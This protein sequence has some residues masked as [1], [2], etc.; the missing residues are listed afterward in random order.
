MSALSAT[1]QELQ[2]HFNAF[3][4]ARA[5]SDLV[6]RLYAEAMGDAY[7]VE[8]AASSSC[9]FTLLGTMVTRLCLRPGQ[10]LADIGCGTGGVGLW[11][12][13]ALALRLTGVDISPTAIELAAARRPAFLPQGR[14]Q[15]R[16]G[17]LE[18]TGLPGGHA[19][20]VVCVDAM[21]NATDRTAAL[22]EIHRIL[23]PGR[24]MIT[25]AVRKDSGTAYGEQAKNAESTSTNGPANPPCGGA[26]TGC[27]SPTRPPFDATSVTSSRRTCCARRTG[28]CP[29]STGAVRA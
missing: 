11:L 6:T 4:A 13:R 16:V 12:A 22:R 15:F 2:K 29:V 3:H 19:H 1:E 25:R 9:D 8:V 10:V 28:C 23:H 14:A 26:C 17:T 24:A 21:S 5:A 20:G 27:G 7:P 18:A